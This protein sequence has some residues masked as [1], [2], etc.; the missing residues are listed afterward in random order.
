MENIK[1][2]EPIPKLVRLS[3]E[4]SNIHSNVMTYKSA[5]LISDSKHKK[6]TDIELAKW[7]RLI[8]KT[9]NGIDNLNDALDFTLTTGKVIAILLEERKISNIKL[10]DALGVSAV[11]VSRWINGTTGVTKE[12]LKKIANYFGVKVECLTGKDGFFDSYLEE[13]GKNLKFKILQYLND[14]GITNLDKEILKECGYYLI[15]PYLNNE[16]YKEETCETYF[17]ENQQINEK[18]WISWKITAE[19]FNEFPQKIALIKLNDLEKMGVEYWNINEPIEYSTEI[20]KKA[21]Y[22]DFEKLKCII[23]DRKSMLA[24]NF[25]RSLES[26][27]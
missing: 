14:F 1:I 3:H 16:Y 22:V 23:E 18:E 2:D 24:F 6:N 13:F 26:I 11:T 17:I 19:F 21:Q 27:K 10:A 15:D 12:N 9:E 25:E 7:F 4:F 20:E 8:A 5:L